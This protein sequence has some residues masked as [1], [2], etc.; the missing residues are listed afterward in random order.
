L[1]PPEDEH[2]HL[3]QTA[4]PVTG[5]RKVED[6]DP[7]I[8]EQTAAPVQAV[9]SG[10]DQSPPAYPAPI[11]RRRWRLASERPGTPK[12][13]PW[14]Q[15][16]C[17]VCLGPMWT[18]DHTSTWEHGGICEEDEYLLRS[19]MSTHNRRQFQVQARTYH[20]PFRPR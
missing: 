9:S 3:E 7:P 5:V 15:T 6:Y 4:E 14:I 10:L 19:E 13:N 17:H 8:V 20:D 11:D 2:T 18:R 16:K 1:A 12:T